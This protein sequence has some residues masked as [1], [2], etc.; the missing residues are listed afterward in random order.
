M[1][2]MIWPTPYPMITQLRVGTRSTSR[3]ELPV[4]PAAGPLPAPTFAPPQLAK[5]S[6][7]ADEAD[8]LN[9]SS[10][11]PGLSWTVTR[12]PAAQTASV[13]WRGGSSND[14]AWGREAVHEMMHFE[15]DDLHP[16][17]SA[18]HG[19]SETVVTL[20]DR[21][22]IWR[23]IL[24]TTSDRDQFVMRFRREL[25]ESGKLIREKSWSSIRPRDGQ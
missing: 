18:V 6:T 14:Y 20:K 2:P 9:V 22:L 8:G 3:L 21:E 19:E 1:W 16:E 17:K 25:Y 23:G 5:A 7:A 10:N 13:D 11:V 4:V 15:A 12:D 24:D